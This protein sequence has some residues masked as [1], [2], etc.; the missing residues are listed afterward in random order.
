MAQDGSI[1]E[2]TSVYT[3]GRFATLSPVPSCPPQ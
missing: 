3:L 2:H 1:D